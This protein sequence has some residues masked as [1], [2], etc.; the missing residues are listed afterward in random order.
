MAKRVFPAIPLQVGGGRI[1]PSPNQFYLTGEDSLRIVSVNAAAAVRVKVACRTAN[2]QGDTVAHSFTHVPA[3]DRSKRTEDFSIGEGSLLNVT[4]FAS[5]G[6]PRI[7]ETY[8][9]VQLVRGADAAAVVLGTILAGCVT[10]TQAIGFPGSPIL[11]SLDVGPVV[12]AVLG[13]QPVVQVDMFEVCP[14]G[15]R[16]EVLRIL[17]RFTASAVA[18]TRTVQLHFVQSGIYV[19]RVGMVKDIVINEVGDCLWAANLPSLAPLGTTIRQQPIPTG[20]ILNAGDYF[21]TATTGL[22][23]GD[24]WTAPAFVVREWLEVP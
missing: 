9:I 20:M 23:A 10:T 1:L 19:A 24:Q 4:V 22:Q 11:S 7:G 6:A 18:G 15:A 5:A 21:L 16:W 14:T 3:T 8:V 12:R 17:S 2:V 13:T